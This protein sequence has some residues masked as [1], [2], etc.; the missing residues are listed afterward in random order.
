MNTITIPI[1]EYRESIQLQKTILSR[2]D[3]LQ[4]IVYSSI[5]EDEVSPK[6]LAKLAKIEKGLDAGKGTRFKNI[7]EVRKYFRSL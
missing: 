7:S 2:L 4:K 3:S 5:A 6:Y 1:K